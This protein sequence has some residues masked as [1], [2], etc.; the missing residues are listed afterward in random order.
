MKR[1]YRNGHRQRKVKAKGHISAPFKVCYFTYF[2][3]KQQNGEK[4]SRQRKVG[5]F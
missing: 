5:Y 3:N 2:R 4:I 1:K